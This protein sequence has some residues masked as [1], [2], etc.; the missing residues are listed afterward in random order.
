MTTPEVLED[1]DQ[2]AGVAASFL[3]LAE[4]GIKAEDYESALKCTQVAAWVLKIQNRELL[5]PQIE[6]NLAQIGNMLSRRQE[7]NGAESAASLAPQRW[8][9]VLTEA[10]PVGGH[11]AMALR[12]IKN[13]AGERTHSVALVGQRAPVPPALRDAVGERGGQIYQADLAGSWLERAAWVRRVAR[14]NATHVVLHIDVDDVVTAAAFAA[15]AGPVTMMV[16]HA[17]HIFWVGAAGTDLVINCRGSELELHWTK[18]FRG[19]PRCAIIPIPLQA[20]AEGLAVGE[21]RDQ[22]RRQARAMLGL[23]PDAIII[24]TSGAT[25]KYMPIGA[26]DFIAT[27]EEILRAVPT[28]IIAAIGPAEDAR[29]R[30]A[31]E[32]TGGRLK[33]FGLQP[34]EQVVLF[35]QAADLYIEGF[36]FGSTTALLESGLH[37]LPAVLAPAACPPPY[38]TDGV[39][40]DEVLHRPATVADYQSRIIELARDVGQREKLGAALRAAVL[41]HHTGAGWNEYLNAAIRQLPARH[42]VY[43]DGA[44]PPTPPTIHRYWA[45]FVRVIFPNSFPITEQAVGHAFSIGTR[46]P[47]LPGAAQTS[48]M[49]RNQVRARVYGD[50]ADA[51]YAGG[52]RALAGQF[53][54]R[55]LDNDPRRIKIRLKQTLLALGPVGDFFRKSRRVLRA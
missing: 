12:W 11:T 18:F 43:L 42:G 41:K 20:P 51:Y 1:L 50:I 38:G 25:Y 37:G 13:D 36:P 44:P 31:R 53:Y 4:A 52:E 34:A 8:L 6:S 48:D 32:R 54:S 39:A 33:T 22:Q 40:V 29:W 27:G 3:E 23:P 28:A 45:N 21:S 19:I 9:H 26:L 5:H 17:A 14:E 47:L 55:S 7:L 49:K 10:L 30:A 46:P 24:L 16:N 15:A 35:Q 2:L